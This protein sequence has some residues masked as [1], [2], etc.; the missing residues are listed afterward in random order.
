MR[1]DLMN[2]KPTREELGVR[3]LEQ[4]WWPWPLSS[5]TVYR[6]PSMPSQRVRW[7][8]NVVGMLFVA[9]LL[10]GACVDIVPRIVTMVRMVQ[11][12]QRWPTATATI[13]ASSTVRSDN[14]SK[15]QY[16]PAIAFTYADPDHPGKMLMAHTFQAA[17]LP[18]PWKWAC[19]AVVARFPVG[20]SHPCYVNPDHHTDAILD[21]DQLPRV[22]LL[23]LLLGTSYAVVF[24]A[25]MS[26][27]FIARGQPQRRI[28]WRGDEAYPLALFGFWDMSVWWL[29]GML[30]MLGAMLVTCLAAWVGMC[31][32]MVPMWCIAVSAAVIAWQVV[33]TVI[34]GWRLRREVRRRPIV[35]IDAL[36]IAGGILSARWTIPAA[37]GPV[38]RVTV[39]VRGLTTSALTAAGRKTFPSGETLARFDL[40][41][42][43][44]PS[45]RAGTVSW[46]IPTDVRP[47]LDLERFHLHWNLC[48]TIHDDRDRPRM[49][50]FPFGI[51]VPPTVASIVVA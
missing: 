20:S 16:L 33:I 45:D 25:S 18:T 5:G 24:L 4:T 6:L 12:V 49:Y 40:G 34:N 44:S 41:D 48:I 26:L 43:A 46:P 19:D 17:P 42:A 23:V 9:W 27:A 51:G 35:V 8:V 28:S 38:R 22:F 10:Y 32:V 39:D 36:P 30:S 29:I 50:A 15:V 7:S 31:L 11:W 47:N 37:F 14:S 3:P 13:T 1:N 21:R 2:G